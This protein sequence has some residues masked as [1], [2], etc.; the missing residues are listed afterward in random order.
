M[1]IQ[2]IDQT[3]IVEGHH[4]GHHQGMITGPTVEI[5]QH[6]IMCQQTKEEGESPDH[7]ERYILE[8]QHHTGE[9][10]QSL[11]LGKTLIAHKTLIDAISVHQMDMTR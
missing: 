9:V 6:L 4:L 1:D 7:H 2:R 3:S 10:H 11:L 5:H 8:T